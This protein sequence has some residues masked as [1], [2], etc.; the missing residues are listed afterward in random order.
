MPEF[1]VKLKEDNDGYFV[2]MG[3]WPRLV[4]LRDFHDVNDWGQGRKAVVQ[5]PEYGV[6]GTKEFQPSVKALGEVM[7]YNEKDNTYTVKIP[8][9]DIEVDPEDLTRH[10]PAYTD[11]ERQ[12]MADGYKVREKLDGKFVHFSWTG[13]WKG[14][15]FD[16]VN[17]AG[18]V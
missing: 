1:E 5:R 18:Q 9:H 2:T 14:H 11:F 13:M 4:K 3:S 17:L 10:R 12:R 16:N 8:E 6:P 7:A 15:K